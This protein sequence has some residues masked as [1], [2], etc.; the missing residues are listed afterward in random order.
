M[1]VTFG[2]GSITIRVPNICD[3]NH[4]IEKVYLGQFRNSEV[5][6]RDDPRDGK[7]WELEIKPK[8]NG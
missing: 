7:V 8:S 5:Q 2:H 6:V 3:A 4:E 1:D